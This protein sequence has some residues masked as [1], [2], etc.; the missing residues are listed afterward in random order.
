MEAER[1]NLEHWVNG[2]WKKTP[3]HWRTEALKQSKT[4]KTGSMWAE[5]HKRRQKRMVKGGEC[6][7]VSREGVLVSCAKCS[8]ESGTLRTQ[9][10]ST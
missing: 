5:G 1:L 3:E 9:T 8:T 10:G 2:R 4:K 7:E 6:I